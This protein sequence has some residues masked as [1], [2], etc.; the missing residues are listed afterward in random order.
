MSGREVENNEAFEVPPSLI[1][2]TLITIT[3][4]QIYLLYFHI[5]IFVS[6]ESED[7]TLL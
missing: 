7:G 6:G 1:T 2:L 3:H 5:L 4:S